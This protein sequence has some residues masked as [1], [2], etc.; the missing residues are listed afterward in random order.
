MRC[1]NCQKER[2]LTRVGVCPDCLPEYLEYNLTEEQ[3]KKLRRRAED[4]LRKNRYY[5]LDVVSRLIEDKM[6][7][8]DD[9]I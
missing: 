1:K 2:P 4:F 3:E 6:I 8:H 7:K 5:M 9:V